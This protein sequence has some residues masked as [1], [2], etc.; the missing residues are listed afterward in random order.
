MSIAEAKQVAAKVVV[1][2]AVMAAKGEATSVPVAAPISTSVVQTPEAKAV[3]AEVN[4]AVASGALHPSV[5]AAVVQQVA[6]NEA[7]GKPV[8]AAAT[9]AGA[10]RMANIAKAQAS[11]AVSTQE[12]KQMAAK[13]VVNEVIAQTKSESVAKTEGEQHST[14]AEL[15]EEVIRRKQEESAR[16]GGV[17]LSSAELRQI[18]ATV[19]QERKQAAMP[20]NMPTS[21]SSASGEIS[22]NDESASSY[23]SADHSQ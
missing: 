18:S 17:P 5:A 9:Q 7:E 1:H 6:A 10:Q 16:R 11:G 4:K 13:I 23:A 14:M 15:A 19:L 22:G 12:A 8:L 21:V 2:E 3:V 20:T